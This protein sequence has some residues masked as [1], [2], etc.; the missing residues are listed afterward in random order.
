MVNDVIDE[1]LS[2]INIATVEIHVI[3]NCRMDRLLHKYV[4]LYV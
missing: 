2:A 3:E 1:I 4:K